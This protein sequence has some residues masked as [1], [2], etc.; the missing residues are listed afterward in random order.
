MRLDAASCRSSLPLAVHK[1]G[2]N[3]GGQLSGRCTPHT[4][5][6]PV[7]RFTV[8]HNFGRLERMLDDLDRKQLPFATAL[9]LT[10]VA[11][12]TREDLQAEMRSSFDRPTPFTLNSVAVQPATRAKPE[13]SVFFKEWAP[14]G[15]PA[16]RYLRPQIDGG[17]RGDKG[18]ERKLR[19]AGLL[20]SGLY[21]VPARGAELD[22]S[23]NV[24]K[25]MIVK[26]LSALSVLSNAGSAG[27]RKGV[28]RGRRR[29]Q[30][31]F[32]VRP[33]NRSGM[34]P[35]IYKQVGGAPPTMVFAMVAQ[36]TYKKRFRFFEVARTGGERHLRREMKAALEYA[37][38][39]ARR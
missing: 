20:P 26:M 34:R 7:I 38:R 25:G 3:E 29:A 18:F 16:G 14:K 23:G 15:V 39:T 35:G 5:G 13:S 11:Q 2:G 1:T 36:P 28:S 6:V 10:R 31:Y 24:S 37:I 19:R 33:G 8:A 32:V 22:G 4:E 21:L 30:N 12:R 17:P 27:N 9:A